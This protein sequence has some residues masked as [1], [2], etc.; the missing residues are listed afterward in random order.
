MNRTVPRNSPGTSWRRRGLALAMGAFL[1]LVL[2]EGACQLYALYLG[3]QWEKIRTNPN[4]YYRAS[5]SEVLGYELSPGVSLEVEGR[6]LRINGNGIRD[7]TEELPA[8]ATK[9]ALL[10]D[11]VVFGLD[12]SQEQTISA[13]LQ[14]RLDAAGERVE[15]L[16]FGCPGYGTA[17]LV[18]HLRFKGA[19]YRPRLVVYVLNPN[20]FCRRNT[21]REGGDTGIYRIYCKPFFKGPWMVRKA[22]YRMKKG[23]MTGSTAW[24]RWLWEGG[25]EA[26]LADVAAMAEVAAS[27]GATFTVFLLPAK[28]AYGPGGSYALQDEH[29]AIKAF[30]AKN[31]IPC[32]DPLAALGADPERYFTPTNHLHPAGNDLVAD[33]L[34]DSL[35]HNP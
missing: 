20:D 14:Q 4:H 10:G 28:C 12:L 33:M 35:G 5:A 29:D 19:I 9:I 6:R 24:Y 8:D 3:F 11:S 26:G 25:G 22:I 15:V 13:L 30:L 2:F 27:Q 7:E 21:V 34:R 17:E 1:S 23:D 31:A 16:N 32:I 18:E